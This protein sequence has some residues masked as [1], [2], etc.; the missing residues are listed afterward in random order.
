MC[1]NFKSKQ[2]NQIKVRCNPRTIKWNLKILCKNIRCELYYEFI[3]EKSMKITGAIVVC[4]LLWYFWIW[5]IQHI[6]SK[7][8]R[9]ISRKLFWTSFLLVWSLFAFNY[10]IR[11]FFP[12]LEA[13]QNG[14][15]SLSRRSYFLLYCGLIFLF[16]ILLSWNWKKRQIRFLFLIWMILF[17]VVG[18]FGL[19]TWIS[20]TVIY[21]LV[22]AYS[23]E[24]LKIWATE[25]EVSKTEFYSSD[26]LFFSIFIALGFSIIENLF[27][28]GNEIF[29][30]NPEWIWGLVFGRWIFTSLLH[31]IATGL[32]ALVLYKF[33]QQPTFKD[34]KIWQKIW[35]IVVA[36]LIWVLI[37]R[38]YNL[39]VQHMNLLIY[40][41]LVFGGYFLLTYL[42]FLSDSLYA[43]KD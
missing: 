7:Q 37:H 20:A 9:Q 41:I 33:Y 23:E 42:L 35:R 12:W 6:F 38:W 28:L 24:F 17:A 25:N 10:I 40:I 21:Y 26:L 3:L 31:F 34:L 22:L 19:K 16:L 39:S 29:S 15:M 8:Q 18:F 2:K 14:A 36:I 43:N 27:Y 11:Y 30:N 4:I 1:Y 5:L 13:I 32:I